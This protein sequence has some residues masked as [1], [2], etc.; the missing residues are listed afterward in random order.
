MLFLG[1]VLLV[2]IPKQ[3]YFAFY[4]EQRYQNNNRY[5]QILLQFISNIN[6]NI[7][8]LQARNRIWHK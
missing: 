7:I 4:K 8:Q 6:R 3:I 5:D 2:E 1:K